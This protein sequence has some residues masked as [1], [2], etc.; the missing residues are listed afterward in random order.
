MTIPI[1]SSRFLLERISQFHTVTV[2]CWYC[3][4][5]NFTAMQ[6]LKCFDVRDVDMWSVGEPLKWADN[7]TWSVVSARDRGRGQC[8]HLASIGE[9]G[10]W[11]QR[12][13]RDESAVGGDKIK[14]SRDEFQ[15]MTSERLIMLTQPWSGHCPSPRVWVGSG[16]IDFYCG[17]TATWDEEKRVRWQLR[18]M[19]VC[20]GS[21]W[22]ISIIS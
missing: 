20:E 2:R 9:R 5:L 12:E 16:H 3:Q 14:L 18:L 8:T 19:S 15:V 6:I 10:E 13:N 17:C 7:D 1:T 22:L 4:S 21:R 11:C